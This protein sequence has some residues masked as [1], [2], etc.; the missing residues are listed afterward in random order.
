MDNYIEVEGPDGTVYEFPSN[1]TDAQIVGFFNGQRSQEPSPPQ[2]GGFFDAVKDSPVGGLVRGLRDIPDAGAQL[3]TEGVYAVAPAGTAFEKWADRQRKGVSVINS[4][5]EREYQDDWRKGDMRDEIDVGRITGQIAGTLPLAAGSAAATTMGR[6]AQGAAA[7]GMAST[8][9][10]VPEGKDFWE[11]KSKQTGVGMLAGGLGP[12][13]LQPVSSLLRGVGDDA[14]RL[15]RAEGVQMTPGQLLG[16]AWK[17][18]EEKLVSV[19][20]LGDAIRAAHQRGYDSF[21][22]AIANRVLKPLGMTA[23][24][25]QV[26]RELVEDVG[27]KISD[28]YDDVLRN[29]DVQVDGQ[30]LDEIDTVRKLAAEYSEDVSGRF[31]KLVVSKVMD[32]FNR[33]A[34]SGEAWKRIESEI[35]RLAGNFKKSADADQRELGEM[36]GVVRSSLRGLLERNAGE[37]VR[38]T[39]K[40]ANEAWSRLV[41]FERAAAQVGSEGGVVTPKAFRAAVK[42]SDKTVRNRGFARGTANQQDIADAAVER[43]APKIPNSGTAD[44]LML[45]GVGLG[46]AAYVSPW[47]AAGALGASALYTSPGQKALAAAL[48]NRGTGRVANTLADKIPI[49]GSVAAARLAEAL[50][51]GTP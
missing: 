23:K 2:N 20:V 33:G 26:G 6:V 5:A 49:P 4:E 40:A 51:S 11:E 34:N 46:G 38:A 17:N 30:F 29:V 44:R 8:L 24:K 15:L 21:N 13:V 48:M 27:N 47:L 19:P 9:T 36:L 32:R 28:V 42:A 39:V 18:I 31:N 1:S 22:A 45:G 43:L 50:R 25:G 14:V 16:G 37:D 35:A 10:P 7:G 12:V 41:V 3:L